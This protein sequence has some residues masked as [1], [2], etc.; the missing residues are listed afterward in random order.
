M[1]SSGL[2]FL[3]G[4]KCQGSAGK[5]VDALCL[6]ALA[7]GMATALGGGLLQMGSGIN[8]IFGVPITPVLWAGIAAIIIAAYT[9]SSYSGL[10]KG[11]KFLSDQNAKIFVAVMLFVFLVGPTRFI[12]VLGVQ[13]FGGFLT[14]F[15][16]QSLFLSPIDG[17]ALPQGMDSRK[18]LAEALKEK[19]AFI[20]GE[21]FYPSGTVKNSFRLNFSNADDARIN[22]G[23]ERL[24]RVIKE[25]IATNGGD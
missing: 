25:L 9:I 6:Y 17:D 15:V 8:F 13:G 14:N 4:D 3:I 12:M 11:I 24:S 2:Y 22:V 20:P 10:N 1:V 16:S 23:I 5:V 19:V 18:V 21:A 7:G